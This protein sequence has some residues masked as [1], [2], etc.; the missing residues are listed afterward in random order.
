MQGPSQIL[1]A[2]FWELEVLCLERWD[3]EVELFVLQQ[4][5]FTRGW[6]DLWPVSLGLQGLLPWNIPGGATSIS[7]KIL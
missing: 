2:S 1:E 6:Q 5:T 7:E 3:R 4:R